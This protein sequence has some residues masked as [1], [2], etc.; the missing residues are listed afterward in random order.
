MRDYFNCK[1]CDKSIRIKSKRKHLNSQ[2]HTFL[3]DRIIFRYIIPN[4][5]FLQRGNI[6][7]FCSSI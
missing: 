6:T 5:E 1:L 3:Y 7:K 4:P 2:Y